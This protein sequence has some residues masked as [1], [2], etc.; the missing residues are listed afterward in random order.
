[1]ITFEMLGKDNAAPTTSKPEGGEITTPDKTHDPHT[2]DKR[3]PIP[4]KSGPA[5]ARTSDI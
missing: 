3:N 2:Y 4:H 1:M 5:V